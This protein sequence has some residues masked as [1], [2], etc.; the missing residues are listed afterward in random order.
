[1][2]FLSPDCSVRVASH[3]VFS[4]RNIV[5]SLNRPIGEQGV[6]SQSWRGGFSPFVANRAL[7][8]GPWIP[9]QG[10]LWKPADMRR[11]GSSSRICKTPSVLSA[12]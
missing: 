4:T 7:Q 6:L 9:S 2:P 12:R 8:H 5:L 3:S 11:V 1:M 10:V